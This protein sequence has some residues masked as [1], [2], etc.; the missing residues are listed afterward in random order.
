MLSFCKCTYFKI[1]LAVID[2]AVLALF[3][4]SV[5]VA[6]ENPYFTCAKNSVRKQEVW[7][8]AA[9]TLWL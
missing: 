4:C 8:G 3:V 6:A 5:I 1:G 7:A 2:R 9:G